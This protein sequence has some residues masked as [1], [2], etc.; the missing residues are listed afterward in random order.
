MPECVTRAQQR[1]LMGS[2]LSQH[3]RNKPSSLQFFFFFFFFEP[4]PTKRLAG[5]LKVF[6][7]LGTLRSLSLS[8]SLPHSSLSLASHVCVSLFVC[9]AVQQ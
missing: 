2:D 8:L 7:T 5:D 6:S 9:V 4:A 3:A 1:R